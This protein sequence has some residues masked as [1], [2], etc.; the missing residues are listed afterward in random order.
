MPKRHKQEEHENHERW[1]VSYADFITLLFAFFVV[2][3]AISEVDAKKA[4]KV[5]KSVQFAFHFE[6][7]G[8]NDRLPIFDGPAG[9]AAIEPVFR[10][11]RIIPI[12]SAEIE[13]A[14]KGA[15]ERVRSAVGT[16]LA[17]V[18][19]LGFDDVVELSL[20]E[21]GLV[22]RL[23]LDGLF[24]PGEDTLVPAA[25]PLIDRIA[26]VLALTGRDIRVEGH[27][28]PRPIHS[29]R[30][31]SNWELSTARATGLVR[32]LVAHH[33]IPPERLSASGYGEYR[34]IDTN[35]TAK[36]RA[37]NRRVDIVVLT[38][39]ASLVE[40]HPEPGG[41]AAAPAGDVVRAGDVAGPPAPDASSEA[42]GA[43][44]AASDAASGAA[45]PRAAADAP[46]DVR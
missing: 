18:P 32:Y 4:K 40:P 3:Y 43:P 14:D 39:R 33:G 31:P 45:V 44:S 10:A 41:A 20:E 6:G 1:L 42:G 5:E 26:S 24:E 35:A 36:G 30:Y 21:R 2:M 28:D 27:A 29:A 37:R 7:T 15:L 12:S 46:S 23:P 38:R 11:P 9:G 13:R 19:S 17:D 34:P 16:N 8:G 22:I 25:L